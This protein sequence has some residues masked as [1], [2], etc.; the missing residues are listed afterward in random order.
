MSEIRN[1]SF[2]EMR[3]HWLR[4]CFHEM[5]GDPLQLY[6]RAREKF[7]DYVRVRILQG[8]HLYLVTHPDG[9]EH[10][11]HKK[12]RNYR[13]PDRFYKSV[14]LLVGNGLFTNEGEGWLRQ[15]KLAQP[16]FHS[17][18]LAVLSPLMVQ[19][20]E[21]FVREQEGKAGEV[22]DICD[23]MMTVGLRIVSTTLLGMDVSGKADVIGKALR[24]GMRYIGARLNSSVML[25]SWAPTK[26]NREFAAAKR[27]LDRVVMEMI[28]ARHQSAQ[29]SRDLLS[30]MMDALDD[31]GKGMA[32]VLL[33]ENIGAALT[34]SWYLLGKHPE[35]QEDIYDEIRGRLGG[36]NPTAEDLEHLPL[37]RAVFEESMRLYPPGW[38][39]LREAIEEDE[40][41]GYSVP[42][43]AMIILC[44]W[45]THRHPDF[46]E[47]AEAFKPERFLRAGSGLRHRFAYF[48]FGGGERI[49]IGMQ[50]S[51]MEGVLVLATVLQRFRVELVEG[52]VVEPDPTFTLRPRWGLKVRL[53][54]RG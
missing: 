10:V 41:E 11:L 40:I 51:L 34:W 32:D 38:G 30:M 46:W 49:C 20:A 39:E 1:K 47:D 44:Q 2:S 16:A 53:R 36:R 27:A 43:K 24:V 4:G 52:Q 23:E 19:G 45:V 54:R 6:S 3:G 48:P 28:A 5:R 9:V 37:T 14:G 13:K 31:K 12:H 15:R 7:G 42:R 18:F 26:V 21:V 22:I 33:R 25:P 17:Q 8:I 29:N 50:F 35:V